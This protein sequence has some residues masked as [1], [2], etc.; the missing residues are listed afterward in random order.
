M[1]LRQRP[2]RSKRNELGWH[3]SFVVLGI[4]MLLGAYFWYVSARLLEEA[5]RI[6]FGPQDPAFPATLGPLLHAEFSRG[7][8]VDLLLNGDEFFPPMLAAIR[9]AKKT[10]TLETYI[11]SPGEIS[12]KFIAALSERARA[13][14]RVHVMLDGMGTL[15]FKDEDRDRMRSAGIE[16]VKYGRQHWYEVKPNINHRTHRK[17]L[18]V[19][20]RVGFTG[21]MCVD[22]H[23]LGDAE[24][25]EVWRDTMVR[26][27]GPTVQQMQSAFASNWLQTTGKLLLGEGYFP[28]YDR[29]GDVAAQCFMSGPGE[30]AQA[31]R[32]SYL[33][34]IASARKSIDI[35]HAYFVPDELA[36]Q[37]L[38]E[39][40]Q[41][42]VRVRVIV[43]AIN[44]SRFGRAASRSRWG[45]LLAQGV[46]FYK[47]QPAMLHTKTMAVDDV[48]VTVGS[49]NFD[50][51]S[52]SIND[53]I[54]VNVID[55]TLGRQHR[56][57]FEE[58]LKQSAPYTFEDHES[59]PFYVK[60]AD[61]FCGLFRSQL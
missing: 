43:P 42:G 13:G 35:E 48:F 21:G 40:R 19:D 50:N 9:D 10:I 47:Y 53:E 57:M 58:D 16:V 55:P 30:G 24:S 25:P 31:A 26:V 41:R 14:V 36:T 56:R 15:K 28:R 20:G 37:V 49:V 1:K 39:A 2:P 12:E 46:E 45:P 52:F 4:A 11:W 3:W 33:L 59:R 29:V 6:D 60:L 51:R 44:D 17:I 34:A 38:L 18:V 61:K 7:N 5:P 23:W 8:A 32:T 54:A 27:E 22:D